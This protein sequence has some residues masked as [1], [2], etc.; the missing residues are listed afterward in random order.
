LHRLWIAVLALI[1]LVFLGLGLNFMFNPVTMAAGFGLV[2]EDVSGVN[3]IR[4]DL[5]GLFLAMSMMMAA[6][7]ATSQRLW[8]LAVAVLVGCIALGRL[9]GFVLD[10]I[11]GNNVPAFLFELVLVPILV[12]AHRRPLTR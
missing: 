6:G 9:L 1:G 7:L 2:A 3:S 8:F 4:G 11:A 5:G 12:M 10:G